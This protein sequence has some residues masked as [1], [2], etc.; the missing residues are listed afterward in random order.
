MEGL[1]M[2]IFQFALDLTRWRTSLVLPTKSWI[3]VSWCCTSWGWVGR[4]SLLPSLATP[5]VPGAPPRRGP[6]QTLSTS[7]PSSVTTVSVRTLSWN[8]NK[9][10]RTVC[11]RMDDSCNASHEYYVS[12]CWCPVH[13]I[14]LTNTF[15]PLEASNKNW[16]KLRSIFWT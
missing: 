16:H 14:L 1:R 8:V 7:T 12:F 15:M 11:T 3:Q 10:I 9:T 13:T 5:P 2:L 4:S 6:Q